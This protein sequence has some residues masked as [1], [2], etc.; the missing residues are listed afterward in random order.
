[1]F[2]YFLFGV[3]LTINFLLIFIIYIL[4]KRMSKKITPDDIEKYILDNY[5]EV[6]DNL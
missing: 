4:Y 1:M 5:M 3:S 2:L 6:G